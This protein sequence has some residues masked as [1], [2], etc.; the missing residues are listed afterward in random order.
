MLAQEGDWMAW[1]KFFRKGS[2]GPSKPQTNK[3]SL[4]L[5]AV[6]SSELH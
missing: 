5:R 6:A 2:C 4:W 3:A 1:K